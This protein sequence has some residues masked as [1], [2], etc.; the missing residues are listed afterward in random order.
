MIGQIKGMTHS[1]DAQKPGLAFPLVSDGLF[2]FQ[3]AWYPMPRN[4]GQRLETRTIERTCSVLCFHPDFGAARIPL[5]S[6][7][8]LS[9][10][11]H[12]DLCVS[13]SM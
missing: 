9:G 6:E 8:G 11:I 13:F 4:E 2:F 7:S 5:F 12:S 3:E 1:L 10:I